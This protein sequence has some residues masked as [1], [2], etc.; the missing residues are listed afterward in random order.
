MT[1]CFTFIGA[2]L[3][4]IT[5]FVVFGLSQL[6]ELIMYILGELAGML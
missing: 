3:L 5:G 1:G 6:C 4:F 2:M